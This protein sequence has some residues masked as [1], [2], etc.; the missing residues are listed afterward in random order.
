MKGWT[1]CGLSLL[2]GLLYVTLWV[3]ANRKDPNTDDWRRQPNELCFDS[4]LN[5]ISQS[6]TDKV[7]KCRQIETNKGQMKHTGINTQRLMTRT[8]Y[9]SGGNT[10][11]GWHW[12]TF[13]QWEAT[14]GR[15]KRDKY[16]AGVQDLS[17]TRHDTWG[18]W[19]QNKTGNRRIY[20]RSRITWTRE[21]SQTRID[22]KSP[23]YLHVLFGRHTEPS[24]SCL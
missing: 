7:Q 3:W 13:R 6:L 1:V 15:D 10:R 16:W 11:I 18:H 21:H 9:S 8:R 17:K 2:Y 24:V 5:I 4:L 23:K 22:R 20:K 19:Y 14:T 12:E